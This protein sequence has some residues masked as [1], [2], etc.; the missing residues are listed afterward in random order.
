MFV[1]FDNAS[2]QISSA[3]L[4]ITLGR[5]KTNQEGAGFTKGIL[6]A[7]SD[8]TCLKYASGAWLYLAVIT[9]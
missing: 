3:D 1:F 9:G 6:V 5:S 2:Q 8:A 7:T 4:I